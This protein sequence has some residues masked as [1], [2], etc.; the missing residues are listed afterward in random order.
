VLS[1]NLPVLDSYYSDP[2]D[3]YWEKFPHCDIPEKPTCDI[4]VCNLSELVNSRKD[5]LSR[6]EF[7]RARK[8]ISNLSSGASSFQINE[9]PS[10][11]ILNPDNISKYGKEV[12]DTIASWVQKGFAAG[13]FLN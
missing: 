11:Q 9:L 12:S 4:N 6:T 3:S 5:V 13:P 8:C 10:C 2:P 1:P 7:A